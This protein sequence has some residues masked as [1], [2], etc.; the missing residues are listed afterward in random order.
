MLPPND[1]ITFLTRNQ[2]VTG[3]QGET[4]L[5]D[6][7]RFVSSVQLCGELVQRGWLT[8]YQQAQILS[9]H[10][11]KLIIGSY[12]LMSPLGEGGMG[13]VFKAIQ[14]KLDRI[15][16]LKIIRPQILASRPEIL[17]RFHR[18]AKAIAQLNHPNVVI[19]FDADEMNDIH[20]IAME[21]VDGDTLEK[22]VR[23]QGPLAIRQ[24]AEYM[25][26]SALGLQHASEVGLVHRD[27]K[28]SNILVIQKG[29]GGSNRSSMR[30]LRP[31]LLDQREA[32]DSRGPGSG[33]AQG[34][35]QVKIL[36]M[37]LARLA[38]IDDER[39]G[40]IEYTP[41]TRA[42]A[43]LGTPDFI[44][45]EQAR[46]ARTV[47]VKADIYS[48]GC[49]FYYL[50]TGKPPFAGGTDVQKLIK[51]QSERPFPIDELRRGVPAEIVQ[52]LARMMEKRPDDRYQTPQHLA[53]A[54]D[55]FLVPL[56]P[57][58]R[59]VSVPHPVAETPAV[60]ETPVPG[61]VPV[62]ESLPSTV[63]MT[64]STAQAAPKS[65]S[66]TITE[67]RPKPSAETKPAACD[68]K[69]ADSHSAGSSGLRPMVS[70]PAHSGNVSAVAISRDG[71][72]IAS[73]GVDG[74]A[75]LWDIAGPT[76]REIGM[77]PRPGVEFTALAFSPNGNCLVVGGA[78]QGTARAWR[79]N[80]VN[81]T[82]LEWGAYKGDRVSV[83]A[84]SISEDSRRCVAAI[85]PSVVLWKVSDDTTGSGRVLKSH[86]T[87]VRSV[88]F[89]PDGRSF[90]SVGEGQQ[91]LIWRFGW[92][93]ARVKVRF[94]GHASI[95]TSVG[96][97]PDN[98][99][100]ATAGVDRTILIWDLYGSSS[101]VPVRLAGHPEDI[102]QIRF[103]K[104]GTLVAVGENGNVAYW[105][106]RTGVKKDEHRLGTGATST[107]AISQTGTRI[108][109]GSPSGRVSVFDVV[110]IAEPVKV[111]V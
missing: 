20:F 44:A 62:A 3:T 104:D 21:Y 72:L 108:L 64:A 66:K 80:H 89:A 28:P 77:L 49:T 59:P 84:F 69:S 9:G 79:W 95:V 63:Q 74:R 81:N 26:Q 34:W 71:R 23:T 43:L 90:A 56:V 10:G 91:V 93:R 54:L 83:S 7:L 106:F 70:I 16:A 5:R 87:A 102:R 100:L 15:I 111:L 46:D 33:P 97:S 53:D 105:D 8:P 101:Q 88:A 38:E 41:L 99:H 37:G 52:I 22:M 48:L 55:R 6:K 29:S 11:E 42:G 110:P 27:I 35:G 1:L 68:K 50:L 86:K 85:G 24:A 14:P 18:E 58:S 107:V 31:N 82:I 92:F 94:Q 32:C 78:V 67:N 60:A 19:L 61:A 76:P 45:P 12:R 57:E 30:L 2:F 75:R 17:S 73:A 4:L 13:M 47:T 103:L 65:V 40:Q 96:F 51:H 36:D 39:E 98:R 109:T 25:R